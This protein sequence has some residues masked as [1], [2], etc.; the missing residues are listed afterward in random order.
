LLRVEIRTL[1]Y[2]GAGMSRTPAVAG[3]AIAAA[4]GCAV[5]EGLALV[6]AGGRADV[7]PALWS[8]VLTALAEPG[9]GAVA[10][11]S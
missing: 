1:V 7:S 11:R 8:E 10:P 5:A 4:R 9:D 3:A 6:T 2:C